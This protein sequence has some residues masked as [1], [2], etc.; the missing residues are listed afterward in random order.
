MLWD[1]ANIWFLIILLSIDFSIHG[2]F[3]PLLLLWCLSKSAFSLFLILPHLLIWILLW[4]NTLPFPSVIYLF[5]YLLM[6]VW[7]VRYL[8]FSVG[9]KLNIIIIYFVGQLFQLFV[10]ENSIKWLLCPFDISPSFLSTFLLEM[11]PFLKRWRKFH[12]TLG[13]VGG[14][15]IG[16]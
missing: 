11:L 10:I 16:H 14:I 13:F 4:R 3:L 6:P 7:I 1:F 8:F 5:S 9:Y 12:W 15:G 2:W